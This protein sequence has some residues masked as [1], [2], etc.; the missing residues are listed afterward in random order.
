MQDIAPFQTPKIE[1]EQYPTGAHLASRLLYTAANAYDEFEGK[2]AIDLGCGTAMLSIGAAMLG[3]RFVLGIDVDAD[4]LETAAENV[5]G[6]EDHLPID[7]LLCDA[8]HVGL[9]L[10]FGADAVVM[11]PPFGTRRKGA[12]MDFLRVAFRLSCHSVYSLHKSS[13]RDH[14]GRVARRELRSRA[15]EPLAQLRYN[16]PNTYKFHKLKSKDIE[17]DLWRFEVPDQPD[18]ALQLQQL[19][20][21]G[22]ALEGSDAAGADSDD[23]SGSEQAP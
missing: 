13:T 11:N 17:V 18:P 12:D 8:A 22:G 7:F 19:S 6:Y 10:R 4:A 15:A 5:A 23:D 1:L 2:T 20:L 21:E 14:V 9:L 16:L 3:A